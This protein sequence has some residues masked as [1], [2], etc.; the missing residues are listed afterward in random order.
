MCFCSLVS[1]T[2]W[3][4]NISI[5]LSNLLD[6]SLNLS[7]I[8]LTSDLMSVLNSSNSDLKSSNWVAM[9]S[10]SIVVTSLNHFILFTDSDNLI[11]YN[12]L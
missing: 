6:R 7:S 11:R 2:Y 3:V 4:R 10:S 8:L 12:K 1:G 9:S 5:G